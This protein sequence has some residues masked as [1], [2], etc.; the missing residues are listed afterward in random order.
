[1]ARKCYLCTKNREM[2]TY[3]ID[4]NI[5]DCRPLIAEGLT[6]LVNQ[7]ET[8]RVSHTFSSLEA[9]RKML[10]ERRPDVLLLDLAMPD[11]E[12]LEFC[13]EMLTTHPRMRIIVLSLYSEY[14]L[15]KR[16]LKSGVHG[17]MLMNASGNELLDTIARVYRGENYI[18]PEVE[19]VLRQGSETEVAITKAE[20]G[21]LCRLCDGRTN[22][23]IASE[24]DVSVETV[25]WYRKRLLAKFRVGNT[26]QLVNK[27]LKE[28]LL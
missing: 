26:V 15:V 6:A 16:L 11:R 5:V 7:S 1:M 22:P 28:R 4:V 24:L 3:R 21:I 17:L 27:V 18:C 12:S 23:E 14:A 25:N 13:H 10:E 19:E 20:R 9:C 8:A 2:K